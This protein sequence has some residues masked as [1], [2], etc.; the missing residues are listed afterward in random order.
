MGL[1]PASQPKI[2][3]SSMNY[4]LSCHCGR[5]TVVTRSQAGQ[6]VLCAC[7]NKLSV[8]TLR[9]L[10]ELPPAETLNVESSSSTT[11]Q[12]AESA[13]KGWRGILVSLLAS[14]L[15]CSIGYGVWNLYLRLQVDTSYT[16]ELE[17]QAGRDLIEKMDLRALNDTYYQF[18]K[19]GVGEKSLPPFKIIQDYAQQCE[20]AIYYCL[21]VAAVSAL[22]A[23]FLVTTSFASSRTK[24]TGTT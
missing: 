6:E 24:N 17:R 23:V 3:V 21:G 18:T 7:G 19:V 16:E 9:G 10:R 15:V 14:V 22:G 13:W 12:A 2:E 5:K 1:A 20:Q 8:P 4:L 11:L